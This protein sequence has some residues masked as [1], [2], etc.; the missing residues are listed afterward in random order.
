VRNDRGSHGWAA[1]VPVEE[2]DLSLPRV[3]PREV[4]PRV[5][6]AHHEH[7]RLASLAG[8]VDEHLE[9]VDLGQRWFE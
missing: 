5:H 6:Q 4:A 8:D 7:V 2:A 3:E 1:N 9:E